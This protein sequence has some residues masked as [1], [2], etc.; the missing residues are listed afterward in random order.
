MR[1]TK[2]N[3]MKE[4]YTLEEVLNEKQAEAFLMLPVRLYKNDR[5]WVRPLDDDIRK[6]FDPVRNPY[7]THGECT[8][9]LLRSISGEVVGRVAAFIDRKVCHQD[10]YAVGGMGFFECIDNRE[11]AF[12]LF[13]QCRDWLQERGM[14]AMEGP[15][16]FGERNDWWGLLVDGFEPAVY[17]MPYN[18]P[19]YRTLFEEYGFRDYFQQYT[20]RTRLAVDNLSEVVVWKSNRLLKNPDYRMAALSE[21]RVDEAKDAFLQVYNQAW[22]ENLYGTGGMSRAQVDQLFKNLKPILDPDL[23]YFAFFKEEPIGFFIMIPE[24]NDILKHLSGNVKG[25]NLLKFIYYRYIR[26]S[27]QVVGLI[28]GV[29]TQFQ[30]RG[31]EAAMIK[32]FCD[33]IVAKNSHYK[34]LQMSW[35]G[36]F[37]KPQMHLMDYIGA[38]RNKTHITYRKLFRDDIEFVRSKDK[39]EEA[40]AAAN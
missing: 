29:V 3:N 34:S 16:N 2:K 10:T 27:D 19:Y 20:Y 23:L 1:K 31:V 25:I 9:W 8:R 33:R 21:I 37:N 14:E 6:V 4:K 13:D 35:V 11:A 39:V 36:D 28:F 22:A 5:N 40:R 18:P 30:K 38:V 15:E 12:M 17:G 7:F 32:Y 26:R 24:L